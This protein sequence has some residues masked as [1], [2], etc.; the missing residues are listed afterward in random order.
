[1]SKTPIQFTVFAPVHNEE[2]NLTKLY[3][4]VAKV[5]NTMGT[6][7]MLLI[8]DGSK[9]QSLQEMLNLQ[10][11]HKNLKVIDL[12]RN[13]GQAI[14][15]DAGFRQA[16]GEYIISLD[17]DLQNDPADIPA[18][19]TQMQEENLDVIA[20]WRQKRKDPIWMLVITTTAQFL[21]KIF[22]NDQIHDSGCTLRIYKREYTEDLELWGEM[23]R[24]IIAILRWH[25]AKVGE[26][27]VNHRPRTIGTT[28][29]TWK[30]SIKGLI[31]LVYIWF[32]RKYSN[33]PLHLFGAT[34]LILFIL[35]LFA[36]ARTI[37]I[38]TQ[39]LSL[40]DSAWT[41]LTIFLLLSGIQLFLFGMVLDLIIKVNYN[42]SKV[43]SRYI[44]R[45]IYE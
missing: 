31:D 36:G 45:K 11:K 14:A 4:E 44:I 6:W 1:M 18:M 13:Y 17:A 3:K 5:M 39:G 40:S 15:M 21:R 8:N 10:N 24:Y 37:Y 28:K 16:Q 23:H 30:K 32:W 20:G 41:M 42:T 9:D 34:G 22:I 2:G 33:R 7:E 29:Y 27:I 25:G 35:G 26:R 12:K 38:Y 43:D 19:F